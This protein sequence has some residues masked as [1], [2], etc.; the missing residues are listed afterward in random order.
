MMQLIRHCTILRRSLLMLAVILITPSAYPD[1][2][3]VSMDMRQANIVD[4]VQ[5]LAKSANLNIVIPDDLQGEVSVKLAN[6]YWEDALSSILHT[7]G[8]G[9]QKQGNVV[10][11]DALDKLKGDVETRVFILK[12]VDATDMKPFLESILS[13]Q[14]KINSLTEKGRTEFSLGTGVGET[15]KTEGAVAKKSRILTITDTQEVVERAAAIIEKLD[16]EPKQIAIDVQIVEVTHGKDEDLGIRWNIEATLRGAK[17]PTTFPFP[18]SATGGPFLPAGSKFPTPADSS[19]FAFGTLDASNFSATLKLLQSKGD[20][21]VLSSPKITTLNNL[22]ASILIGEH[23]PITTESIDDKTG[24]RTISLDHYEDIGIQLIVIP[25]VS[26]EDAINMIIHPAVST[27]GELVDGRYPRIN[28][29]E[30]DTQVLVMND[31]T[32]V[33][34]GLLQDR[35][36]MNIDKV[37]ILGSIPVLKYLFRHKVSSTQKVELIIFVTPRIVAGAS[38]GLSRDF[39][40]NSL[41]NEIM[42]KV[43]EKLNLIPKPK[44]PPSSDAAKAKSRG[45]KYDRNGGR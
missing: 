20:V 25:Q 37:P 38:G 22:Q 35:D 27:I 32:I 33:I 7:K 39:V 3:T 23:F 36:S 16:L 43:D 12:Y 41:P 45:N 31:H 44:S 13:P 9:Y 10:R 17:Q 24:L 1:A 28:T 6:V 4:V 26:G 30:A 8:F 14:G 5:L 40:V 29:R 34:G 15:Q 21:N 2:S 11:I 19:N 18:A 42:T